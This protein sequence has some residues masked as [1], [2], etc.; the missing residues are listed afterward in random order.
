VVSH[1]HELLLAKSEIHAIHIWHAVEN[2]TYQPAGH[3]EN[4]FA[5]SI[6]FGKTGWFG[7]LAPFFYPKDG[8]RNRIMPER[9]AFHFPL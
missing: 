2:L 5:C 6:I 9:K 8:R 1:T 4:D 3:R 7:G